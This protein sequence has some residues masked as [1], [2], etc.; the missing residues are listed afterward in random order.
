MGIACLL[1]Y[2]FPSVG[3]HGGVIHAEY[4]ILYGAVILVFLISGM[5]IPHHKLV[6]H[7]LNWRLH[8][9]V[10]GIS[11][12]LIPAIMVGLVHLIH[13]TDAGH[14]IDTAVLAGYIIVACLPTTIAS[15]VVM[16]RAAGGDDAAALVEVLVANILGPFVTPGWAITLL[17]K[18]PDFD[19]WRNGSANMGALYRGVFK[20]L[21]FTVLIPLAIGQILRWTWPERIAR[22]VTKFYLAKVASSC[23]VLL[24]W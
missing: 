17:P 21:G 2:F 8:F 16:T 10:Q 13:A 12:L 11:Y 15:N 22:V 6:T 5:S 1:A 18:S 23:L 4:T 3:K 7:M 14:R 9:L 19:P 20:E 24:V